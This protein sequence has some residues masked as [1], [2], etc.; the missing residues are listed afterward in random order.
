MKKLLSVFLALTLVFALCGGA[1]AAEETTE[2]LA[3]QIV[4]LHTNDVHGAIDGYAK[5]AAVKS[6]YE[7]RGADVLLFDAGDYIQGDPTVSVSQ[8]ATAIELMNLT[9]YDLAGIGNHEFDYGYDNLMTIL[10]S[11]DFDVLCAHAYR[12]AGTYAAGCNDWLCGGYPHHANAG[13]KC[14]AGGWKL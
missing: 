6:D 5:I 3:G 11:A 2:D 4:I 12:N 13:A 9:G 1:L 10:E 7:A 14:Q 8:G